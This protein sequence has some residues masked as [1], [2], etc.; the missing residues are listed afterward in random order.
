M[1]RL[2]EGVG[3]E[4]TVAGDAG[5]IRRDEHGGRHVDMSHAAGCCGYYLVKV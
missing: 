4:V 2:K 3:V 1:I 5:E